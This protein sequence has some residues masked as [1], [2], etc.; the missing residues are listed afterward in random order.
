MTQIISLKIA[1]LL[2]QAYLGAKMPDNFEILR[3]EAL[4]ELREECS[5]S[6]ESILETS[7]FVRGRDPR[8]D[9]F[10]KAIRERDGKKCMACG[11]YGINIKYEVA[12]ILP[13][14]LFPEYA[15]EEWNARIECH[16]CNHRDGTNSFR[17]A[18][19]TA[20]NMKETLCKLKL[21]IVS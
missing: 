19:K 5:K 21:S 17:S 15:F 18:A 20:R 3:T 12:H 1:E 6:A 10:V 4:N 11:E 9:R 16:D 7:K 13:V 14:E 8:N 2:Q